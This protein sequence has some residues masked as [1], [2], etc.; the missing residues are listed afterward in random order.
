MEQTDPRESAL[1]AIAGG[2]PIR[3]PENYLV[4]GAPVLGN[5]EREAVLDCIDRRW[6]GTGPRA[7]EFEDRFA[8]MR[9]AACAVAVHS[10]TAAMQLALLSLGVGVGDEVVIP[11]MTYFSTAH[12]VKHAG[13]IP[14]LADCD[15]RTMNVTAETI[16][17]CLSERTKAVMVVH[18]AGRCC[19][20]DPIMELAGARR[21]P[22]IEDCAHAVESAYKG[23]PAGTM[24][25][26]GCFSFYATK[27]ITAGEGGMVVTNDTGIADLVRTLGNQ[28]MD[29]DAWRRYSDEGYR[30]YVARRVGFKFNMPD[31]CAAIGLA[32]LTRLDA[33]SARRAAVWDA[34][35]RAFTSLPM[36]LPLAPE[37][38]TVHARHL[39]TPL[40]H[41]DALGFSRDWF[42]GA[43]SAENIG[44][45]VHFLPV[46][47]H[48]AHADASAPG[49]SSA[50]RAIGDATVSLPLSGGMTDADVSDVVVAVRRIIRY[51][52]AAVTDA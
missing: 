24:G 4:F 31:I 38:G 21:I 41:L 33:H 2:E 15:P 36:T 20:M 48:E 43:L 19:D 47:W 11:A 52:T 30:H 29:A 44:A 10:C 51:G 27:N 28:G 14:V 7:T 45:G 23:R 40:L 39:Y 8:G 25:A 13:A 37:A 18:F 34:Y 49:G 32:Q 6:L 35:D 42:L 1:P 46:N 50:S 26:V 5:A 22:V 17:A 12:A 9:G 16:R 3:T